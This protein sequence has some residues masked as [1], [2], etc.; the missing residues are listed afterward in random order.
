MRQNLIR[1][2][3]VLGTI[4]AAA[5]SASATIVADFTDDFSYPA[6][7]PGWSYLSHASGA[8]GNSA[9]YVLLVP[10]APGSGRYETIDDAPDSFPDAAPGSSA[11]ATAT[12]LTPGQ[13][14][15]QNPFERYVLAAYTI[16]AADI[17]ANGD[18]VV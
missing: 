15:A 2:S 17:A 10:D 3:V 16:S 4:V 8:I 9:N 11:S 13:G 18:Q 1:A 12:T 7:A 5:T 14:T 6:P